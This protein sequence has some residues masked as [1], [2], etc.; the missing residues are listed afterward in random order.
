MIGYASATV[1]LR[2]LKLAMESRKESMAESGEGYDL[3]WLRENVFHGQLL[4]F[5]TQNCYKSVHEKLLKV[6]M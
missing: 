2:K 6:E 3:N 5:T 1:P 4:Q